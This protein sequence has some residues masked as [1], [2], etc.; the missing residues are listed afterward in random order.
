MNKK[1][2]RS[3][4]LGLSLSLGIFTAATVDAAKTKPIVIQE[5]GSFAFGGTKVKHSGVFSQE[6]FLA[7][8]GQYA[9]G[10]T[11]MQ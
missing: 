10:G 6:N 3:V 8:E 2:L 5:Q 7:P 4:A 1:F 9:Y 11:A